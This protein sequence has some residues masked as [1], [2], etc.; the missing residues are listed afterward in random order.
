MSAPLFLV[1]ALPVADTLTLDGPEG[2][3]AATVQRLRVGEELILADG[4]G[5]TAAAVVTAVGRGALD[6]T[7]TSRGYVDA[8]VPRIVVVQGI[9]KG[10]RGELAVQAM[11]E[12]GVDEIVPW[13]AS[14]SVTQWRG[15]RGVRAREKW[16]ATAREAAKQAR[17]AWLPVVAGAP[18]ES[19]ATVA[20]RI[21]GAAAGFVLH[22]E[23][24][25]R[26]TTVELPTTGEIVLVVGPEGG[27]APAEVDA[28]RAAGARPVRLGPAVL[29]TSTAGV[30]ALS[31]LATRLA[32]W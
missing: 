14:R 25:D 11:T 3:H 19:T 20:A 5:G 10:E 7:V 22:E 8:S 21:S 13:A 4:R 31:V 27:I 26:L 17:R 12:V 18:D 28:F 30:A 1:E 15:E 24:Q 9:A 2:H 6:L 16:A 32:R 23:A 29:R